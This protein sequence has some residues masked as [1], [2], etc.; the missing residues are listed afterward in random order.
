MVYLFFLTEFSILQF[1]FKVLSR[2][3]IYLLPSN[4][5]ISPTAIFLEK[6]KKLFIRFS[7]VKPIT[8]IS[9]DF[10]AEWEHSRTMLSNIFGSIEKWQNQYFRF[11]LADSRLSGYGIA[12]RQIVCNYIFNVALI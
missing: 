5:I 2:K 12:Y 7:W 1:L 10:T 3:K 6:L 9:P 8:A 11:D 4:P